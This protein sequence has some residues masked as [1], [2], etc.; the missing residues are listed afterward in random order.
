MSSHIRI[1]EKDAAKFLEEIPSRTYNL[2]YIDPPFNTGKV[3]E[4]HGI[5]YGDSRD[6]WYVWMMGLIREAHRVLCDDGT[7]VFHIDW[8]EAFSARKILNTVFGESNFLNEI[9]WA[10]DFGARQK[11]KWATKHDNIY[12]YVKDLQ[13]YTFNYDEMDRIPY[14]APGL[15]GKEKASRGKTPTDV[16]WH[17]I[18]PTNGKERVGYPTQKPIGMVSRFV[19]VHSKA[20]DKCLDFFA[21]SGTFG[22]CC[23]LNGR[24]CDNVDSNPDAC[25]TMN[26]RF[27]A[28]KEEGIDIEISRD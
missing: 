23:A 9:I 14:M 3:Q 22:V 18:V 20:E 27:S 25:E 6:H 26:N 21:G 19:K 5:R 13:N 24:S 4:L 17:T 2:I 15:V 28:L 12:I 1:I 7:L 16:W 8:H 10:Y 11:N